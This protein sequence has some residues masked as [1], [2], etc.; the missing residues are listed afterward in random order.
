MFARGDK[1]VPNP[2]TTAILRAGELRD[3][4]LYYRYDLEPRDANGH[5]VDASGHQ[6]FPNDDP[7]TFAGKNATVTA[8]FLA[9]DGTEIS[10]PDGPGPLWETPIAGPLPE[11]RAFIGPTTFANPK[12]A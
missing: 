8:T 3:R 1:T 7:H 11:D 10:D 12:P 4:T 9:S 5:P 2:T 6:L